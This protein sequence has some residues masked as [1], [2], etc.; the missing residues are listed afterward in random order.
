ML[1]CGGIDDLIGENLVKL[2][3]LG[4]EIEVLGHLFDTLSAHCGLDNVF[5]SHVKSTCGRQSRVPER[6]V[7]DIGGDLRTRRENFPDLER[8]L[9]LN[10]L[11]H[12]HRVALTLLSRIFRQ[13]RGYFRTSTIVQSRNIAAAPTNDG[14]INGGELLSG[15]C[16]LG[17]AV[18]PQRPC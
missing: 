7:D 5:C 16:D 13:D 11:N 3:N 9:Q 18:R 2:F 6:W 8:P 10:A 14:L 17:G 4:V 1:V 15:R 12:P